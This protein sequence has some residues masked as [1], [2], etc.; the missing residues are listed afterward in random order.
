[1][2]PFYLNGMARGALPFE[3][4]GL[5]SR[6]RRFAL[7]QAHAVFVLGA[8]FDFRVD[9]GRSPTW[10]ADAKIVQIDLDGAELGRN[11]KVDVTIHGDS[12]LVLQQLV[13]AVGKK[14]DASA[15]SSGAA[16]WLQWRDA[17]RAQETK[18]RAKMAAEIESDASP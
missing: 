8:P 1:A 4:A 7:A 17:V 18:Q 14:D 16:D 3:H 13:D 6:S 12:G 11:R 9:Y 2:V 5:F 10:A 15:P